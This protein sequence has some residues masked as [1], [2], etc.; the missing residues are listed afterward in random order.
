[1][2]G[3]RKYFASHLLEAITS[4]ATR[5]YE[6][7][8]KVLVRT[9]WQ[10][11]NWWAPQLDQAKLEGFTKAKSW[12]KCDDYVPWEHHPSH[13]GTLAMRGELCRPGWSR[14]SSEVCLEC[15]RVWWG[16]RNTWNSQSAEMIAKLEGRRTFAS[17]RPFPSILMTCAYSWPSS[18]KTS[19]RFSLSFSFLPRRRFLPPWSQK[20]QH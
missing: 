20:C 15:V 3:R 9:K 13:L 19:S 11:Q 5:T 18:L 4:V 16:R 12:T 7:P 14:P 17:K 1:M 2:S 8:T 10:M 6:K